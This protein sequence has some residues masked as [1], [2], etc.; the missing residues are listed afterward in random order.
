MMPRKTKEDAVISE[1]EVTPQPGVAPTHKF[2][3]LVD[4]LTTAIEAA[5]KLGGET[6][7]Y[8]EAKC[9]KA[10]AALAK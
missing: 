2:Q 6:G 7:V 4:A 3:D 5:R 1:D 8:V 10:L 9:H